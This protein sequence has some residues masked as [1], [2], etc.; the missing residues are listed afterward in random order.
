MGIWMSMGTQPLAGLMPYFW[1]SFIISIFLGDLLDEIIEQI[2][3]G[4]TK[5]ARTQTTINIGVDTL[6]MFPLDA[7]DRN[8]TSPFAFT[9]NK[10]EFRAVGSSQTCA[11]VSYTHLSIWRK[12]VPLVKTAGSI[13]SPVTFRGTPLL[14]FLKSPYS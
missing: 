3:K 11:S 8:R 10:F 4:G 14:T 2:E 9:G 7:S 5:K 13:T 6:P 12:L 1:Y